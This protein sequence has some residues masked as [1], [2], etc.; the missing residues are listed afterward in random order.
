M[1]TLQ[2]AEHTQLINDMA[3]K[4]R[5][6]EAISESQLVEIKD[7]Q[8][9]IHQLQQEVISRMDEIAELHT[10]VRVY[11]G[12]RDELLREKRVKAEL[13]A[14]PVCG[15]GAVEPSALGQEKGNNRWD[16]SHHIREPG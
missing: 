15:N 4:I 13:K 8:K 10:Q 6:Q 1:K 11:R 9:K 5:F 3:R 14:H 7:L 12:E 16:D 2:S